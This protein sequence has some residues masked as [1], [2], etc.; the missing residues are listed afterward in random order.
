[1]P[2]LIEDLRTLGGPDQ[3]PSEEA[4]RLGLARLQRQIDLEL[5]PASPARRRRGPA[6]GLAAA[7]TIAVALAAAAALAPAGGPGARTVLERAAAAVRAA[8]PVILT[9]DIHGR[10]LRG[11]DPDPIADYGTNRV[12]VRRVPGRGTQEFRSLVL[13]SG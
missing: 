5:R 8:E 12:W 4:A 7:A 9:A 3:A 11:S 2:D 6:L 1:M 13:V 10:Q